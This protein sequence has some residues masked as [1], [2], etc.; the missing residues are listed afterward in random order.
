[1]KRTAIT[2][3]AL[4]AA[5]LA[6]CSMGGGGTQVVEYP[7]MTSSKAET[8]VGGILEETKVTEYEWDEWAAII[9]ES[10]TIDGI[11]SYN[12]SDYKADGE[13]KT[14]TS[15]RAHANGDM[16]TIISTYDVNGEKEILYEEFHT[17]GPNPTVAAKRTV[18]EYNGERK[19]NVK[20]FENGTQ[21]S[22]TGNYSYSDNGSYTYNEKIGDGP[23]VPMYYKVTKVSLDNVITGY[24][25]YSGW[26]GS[27]GT[28]IE[29]LVD[30]KTEGM[31]IYYTINKIGADGTETETKFTD[32]YKYISVTYT[33]E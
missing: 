30:Y 4:A 5:M 3:T 33:Y 11:P 28:K 29:E 9:G 13:K 15:I 18:T 1:M 24:E 8:Y 31:A 26:D 27:T 16:Y 14:I 21:V 7:R 2:F 32:E 10:Q 12:I 6:G 23:V 20:R 22:E 19:S 17:N 25:I